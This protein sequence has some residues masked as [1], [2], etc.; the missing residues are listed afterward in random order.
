MHI[1]GFLQ[2]EGLKNIHSLIFKLL[3]WPYIIELDFVLPDFIQAKL[4]ANN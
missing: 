3:Q 2:Y 1:M 4:V